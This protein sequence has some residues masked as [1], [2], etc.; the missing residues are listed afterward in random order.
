MKSL[1]IERLQAGLNP[2]TGRPEDLTDD[3]EV[4][5]FNGTDMWVSP[6]YIHYE[7]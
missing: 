1:V 4:V 5:H 6:K 2:F 7:R 3:M